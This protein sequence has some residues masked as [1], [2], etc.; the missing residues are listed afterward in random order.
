MTNGFLAP[1]LRAWILPGSLGVGLLFSLAELLGSLDE[2]LFCSLTK[3]LD[4]LLKPSLV[5]ANT[6]NPLVNPF[7][8]SIVK[9]FLDSLVKAILAPW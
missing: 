9:A 8:D 5:L 2:S 6:L 3:T 4:P 1:Y 7:L